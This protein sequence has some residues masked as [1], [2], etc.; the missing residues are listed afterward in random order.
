ME[1]TTDSLNR[2]ITRND[3]ESVTTTTKNFLQTKNPG[4]DGFTKNCQILPNIKRTYTNFLKI[5][6]RLKRREHSRDIL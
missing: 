4:P 6:Q 3:V 1:E 5:F 2:L